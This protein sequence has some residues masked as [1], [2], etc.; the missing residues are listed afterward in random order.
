[1]VAHVC[2]PHNW[3]VE[4]GGLGVQSSSQLHNE[5]EPSLAT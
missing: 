5:F 1:M 4:G 3:D 2:I